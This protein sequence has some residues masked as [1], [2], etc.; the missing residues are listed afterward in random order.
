MANIYITMLMAKDVI[1]GELK[2]YA[3]P[4]IFAPSIELATQ[5]CK[6]HMPFLKV[7]G[8]LSFEAGIKDNS[9]DWG[10]SVDYD[11]LNNN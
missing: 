8:R 6:E 9:I 10:N 2:E 11:K 5:Y 3:G 1:T 7:E 4:R